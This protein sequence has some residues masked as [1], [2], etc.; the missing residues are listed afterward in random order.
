[1]RPLQLEMT[2]FGSYAETTVLPFVELKQGLYLVT[3]DTG[4]GKTTIFDAIM[5]AL[6][7]V[8][9]GADRRSDM[10]HCD[11]VAKSADT[12]VKLCFSQNGKEYTAERRIHYGKKRGTSDQYGEPNI[13][14]QL[15]G[16]D[17][18]PVEG[19]TRVTE[20]C[21]ALLGLNAD[22]FSRIIMLAQ[23]EF[24]KFLKANSDEKNDI[25]GKLFDNSAYVYYQNL[26]L[27]ARDEL[28]K[29]RSAG[30]EELYRLMESS[31]QP[32][33]SLRDEE[34]EAFLPGHPELPDN[35]GRL[36][37]EEQA[38]LD[39]WR[40]RRDEAMEKL[41]A[42]NRKQGEASAMNALLEELAREQLHLAQLEALDDEMKKRQVLLERRDTALH[43]AM[44]AVTA[45]VQAGDKLERTRAEIGELKTE[46]SDLTGAAEAAETDV[47]AD[48]EAA[49]EKRGL[50]NRIHS[51]EEL[52][53]LYAQLREGEKEKREAAVCL[54]QL[55]EARTAQEE[56]LAAAKE[57]LLALREKIDRLEGIDAVFAVRRND[58]IKAEEQVEALTGKAGL[59][60]EVKLIRGM[61]KDLDSEKMLL[62]SLANAA[63]KASAQ[64]DAL[65]Q[66]FIAAQ[67]AVLAEELRQTLAE[68]EEAVCPVCGTRVS[69]ERLPFLA[70]L[71]DETPGKDDVDRARKK[72]EQA[73]RARSE[74]N[75]A[76]QSKS[77]AIETRMLSAAERGA[78]LLPGCG[79]WEA[80]IADGV[81]DAA[82]E[83]ARENSARCRKALTAA[84]AGK[85]EL[86]E[87]REK[88]P[89]LEK[90]LQT[91]QE[92]IE[93]LREKE[94][95]WQG[96]IQ[97]KDAAMQVLRMQLQDE[98][99][100]QKREE[101][102]RLETRVSEIERQITTHQKR[103]EELRSKK[104]MVQ[105]SL[106]EK[107]SAELKLSTALKEAMTERD[108]VLGMTGFRDPA[109]VF[110]TLDALREQDAELWIRSERKS[111]SEH[112]ISKKNTRELIQTR[113]SQTEGK[114]IVDLSELKEEILQLSKSHA[115]ANEACT[116]QEALL[117]N[118]RTVTEKVRGIKKAL[119]DSDK[120]WTRLDSLASLAGGINSESGRLSF[121]RY[122]MGTMFREIL[123]MAN[124]RMALMSGGRYELV[125]KVGADR[126]NAKAGLEIEVLD[127]NTGLQRASGSLS[128]GET[129]FTS[130]ALALGLSDVVQ[131][132]A[133]GKQMDALFIDEG[134][135]TLSDDVLDKALEVLNQLTEGRRLVGIISHVD[136]LDES[137]PQ[138][139]RVRHTE[140]GSTLSLELS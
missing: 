60:S 80:L 97:A 31:F 58:A 11:Y 69:G 106:K 52:L 47:R 138:K 7:G 85:A 10:L 41:N 139:V 118:H 125:H 114:Q 109:A 71:P 83:A 70:Q 17:I 30:T 133:G 48:E 37:A 84:E 105:G 103:L 42:L 89:K 49:K 3:G 130:L 81:L 28:K 75:A 77:A 79:T 127:N 119:A 122:V 62:F 5:F 74:Q 16:P 112:E 88:R 129:F 64:A 126:R 82:V 61:E 96:V 91:A 29:R 115:A 46:L 43:Q 102:K 19:S 38:S 73:E 50:E 87:S 140:K 137:I 116:K 136:R 39:G 4:A 54:R 45:A 27:G 117:A 18:P 101:K 94:Q 24:K 99:E 120:A 68:K 36:I 25:L 2:A 135:G 111:L 63:G 40:A 93:E 20:R 59:C 108:R 44:P 92:K 15:T 123:E 55:K 110:E 65:Y 86:D 6:F 100:E 57:E 53:P 1:M 132:H 95:L 67:A 104:D 34:K 78:A 51:I 124:Q 66:Q 33:E 26:L 21:E 128:G 32:P 23:G 22:Q 113:R 72:A 131:N 121:D 98:N 35:L 90:V 8:A 9:S 76:V 134:F 13:S 56:A 107:E 14:A 12:V